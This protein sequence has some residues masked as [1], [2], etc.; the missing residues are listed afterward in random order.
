M[1]SA[2]FLAQL[3]TQPHEVPLLYVMQSVV[4]TAGNVEDGRDGVEIVFN[5]RG[6][7]RTMSSSLHRLLKCT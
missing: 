5:S 3:L 1:H 2:S 6:T 7:P 4:K